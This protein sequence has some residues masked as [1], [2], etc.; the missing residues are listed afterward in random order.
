MKPYN[1]SAWALKHQAMLLYALC[2]LLLAGCYS[3]TQLGQ[4]EDPDFTFK[5]MTVTLRWSGATATEIE[6]QVV[7][8]IERKLQETP[9]LD[10]VSSYS[11]AGEAVLY[12]TL[13]DAMPPAELDKSWYRVRKTLADLRAGMPEGVSEPIINDD[14]GN[15]ASAIYAFTSD[16]L[17]YAQLAA[18][19]NIARDELL[20]VAHVSKVVM[21]G[22]QAEKIYIEFSSQKMAALGIDPLQVAAA[23]KARNA[24]ELAG[25][26]ISHFDITRLRVSGDFKSLRSIQDIGIPANGKIYRLGDIC[27]V[28]RGYADPASFKVHSMGKPAIALVVSMSEQ[29]DV[30]RLGKDL[31]REMT[32]LKSRLPAS[33]QIRQIAD[34]SVVVQRSIDE[35]MYV[36]L[37]ALAIVLA[38]SFLSLGARA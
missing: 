13:K 17:D 11:K 27:H 16:T 38:V 9:W 5:V 23:L 36:L 8:R 26:V 14:F 1:L 30:T 37:E 15:T 6:Q 25:A 12:I 35:F 21:L 28:Y 10:N 34:Q 2:A 32:H 29:G 7:D 22:A 33:I 18:Q 31:T 20:T 24:M 3:Y 19:A 4:K